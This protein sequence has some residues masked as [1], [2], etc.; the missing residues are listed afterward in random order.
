MGYVVL[1]GSL[2]ME[3][4]VALTFG[5]CAAAAVAPATVA[6]TNWPLAF[7]MYAWA[8]EACT[9]YASST[10]PIEPSV[11]VI[12]WATAWL[13]LPPTPVGHLTDLATPTLD[14]HS[15]EIL[16]R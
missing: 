15:S 12:V 3:K 6:W 14:F 2:V 16:A 5:F 8:I 11:D 4:L 9:T 7:L 10:Y 13:P 1:P